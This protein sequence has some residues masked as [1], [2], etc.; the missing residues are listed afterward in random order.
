M[1]KTHSPYVFPAR[2]GMNRTAVRGAGRRTVRVFPAR[3]GMNRGLVGDAL[4]LLHVFPARA[5][6]NRSGL[7]C[8]SVPR[9]RGDEPVVLSA[10]V[11]LASVP[12]SSP[13][14]G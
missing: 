11:S 2:A 12:C 5:G 4:A 14:R 3:A 6:M 13:A 10:P 7:H 1:S 8:A 9:P